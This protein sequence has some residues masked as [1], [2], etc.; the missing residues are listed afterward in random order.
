M[1]IVIAGGSG[2]IGK[3]LVQ[4]LLHDGEQVVI[5]SRQPD[6][7]SGMPSGVRVLKWDGKNLDGWAT[8]IEQTDVVINLTGENL[9]GTG[10]IPSRWT[11]ARKDR[12]INSRIDAGKVLTESILM[13]SRRPGVFVQSS[14]VG[15]YGITRNKILTESDAAGNDFLAQLCV[16]WEA[17]S[18]QVE[19]IGVRRIII[20]NG[21]VLTTESGALPLLSLPYRLFVGGRLGSGNQVYS[22]IHIQDEVSA[23]KYLI[24]NDNASGV[25]NLTSPQPLSNDEFGRTIGKV[26]NRPHYFPIPAPIMNLM[27]GEVATMVLNGQQV[28][29]QKLL[30]LGYRFKFPTLEQALTNLL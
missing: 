8:E 9:S 27:L 24:K 25:V 2:L 16:D 26:I 14:G 29:P 21:V 22:W 6:L 3:A 10:F 7:V 5:L 20:R 12:I 30:D 11:S 17:S 15:Y 19:T 23:I 13:A 4:E 18:A 1:R 28:M